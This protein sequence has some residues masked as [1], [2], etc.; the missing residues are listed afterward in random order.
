MLLYVGVHS[1]PN[2]IRPSF[3][4]ITWCSYTRGSNL[5]GWSR[6]YFGW[7]PTR[8]RKKNVKRTISVHF[9]DIILG[10]WCHIYY[11]HCFILIKYECSIIVF[12]PKKKKFLPIKNFFGSLNINYFMFIFHLKIVNHLNTY[13]LSLLKKY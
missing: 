9:T 3:S 2:R 4:Y 11:V 10:F 13:T 1:A 7:R 8:W 12:K 6:S 5:F